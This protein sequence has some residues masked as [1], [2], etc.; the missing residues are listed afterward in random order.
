MTCGDYGTAA[1]IK[2]IV[3]ENGNGGGRMFEV[4]QVIVMRHDL[5]MRMGKVA[6]QAAH[7]SIAFLT[8]KMRTAPQ[9]LTMT[10]AYE[11]GHIYL[12]RSEVTWIN[13]LFTKICVRVDS[14]EE[15]ITVHEAA[16]GASLT[17]ILIRDAGLTEFKG[18]PT[19]TCCAIGPDLNDKVDKITGHLKLL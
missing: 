19:L 15:L 12:S 16:L 17:S 9:V 5:H 8:N 1:L 18:V 4:K 2:R 3:V 11:L 13:D 6:A 14:E 10:G 7:A